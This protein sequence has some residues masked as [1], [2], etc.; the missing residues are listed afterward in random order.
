MSGHSH[1]KT[2]LHKKQITDKKRSKIFSK[3]SREI[4]IAV[5]E[6]S[7]NPATNSKLRLVIEKA[8]KANMPRDQIE[9]AIERG[10]GKIK[11]IKL[12]KILIEAI[13]L[14]NIAII[15]EGITDNR[16]RTL[17]EIRKILTKFNGK[18]VSSGGIKW[19]FDIKGVIT[20]DTEYQMTDTKKEEIELIV[21]EAGAED[22][23]WDN[24]ILDI[25]TKIENL[26]E[27]K[28]KLENQG[29]KIESASLDWV[30]KKMI[31]LKESDKEK[32]Q[33]LFEALDELDSVQDVYSNIK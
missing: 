32:C 15:V 19:L 27:I 31:E 1:A 33:E 18:L 2:V 25:Y 30:P 10:S 6:G 5:K 14:N 12:E 4:S 28:K 16:N 22:I 29:I 8:K 3:M 26:E 21:I 7:E 11:G 23:F 17:G 9:R 24:S 13:G 20:I